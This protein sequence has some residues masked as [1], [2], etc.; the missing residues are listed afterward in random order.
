MRIFRNLSSLFKMVSD[1]CMYCFD[2]C[3]IINSADFEIPPSH[4]KQFSQG[5]LDFENTKKIRGLY[6]DIDE[7]GLKRYRFVPDR[8]FKKNTVKS[9]RNLIKK[10]CPKQIKFLEAEIVD[11][12]DLFYEE[13]R[14]DFVELEKSDDIVQIQEFFKKHETPLK[15]TRRNPQKYNNIPE[16][17]DCQILASLVRYSTG[18]QKTFISADEHFWAYGEEIK[19]TFNIEVV[20]E[21]DCNTL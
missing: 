1:T 18:L 8:K 5:F 4:L 3:T 19:G 10:Y 20:Q 7:A 2:D 9:I 11:Q 17:D 16:P 21:S 12:A 6:N 15:K 13:I 14:D